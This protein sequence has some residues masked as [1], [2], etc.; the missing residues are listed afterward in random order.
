MNFLI[1]KN[2]YI[3]SVLKDIKDK[4]EENEKINNEL[5]KIKLEL[6]C[7]KEI[8]EKQKNMLDFEIKKNEE[9]ENIKK[10]LNLLILMLML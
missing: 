2:K 6:N 4:N 7:L 10:C 5:N 9:F 3:D 1:K 8:N